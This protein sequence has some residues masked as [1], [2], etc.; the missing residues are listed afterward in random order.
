M[1][2]LLAVAGVG[3]FRGGKLIFEPSEFPRE[4]STC[5]PIGR[6]SGPPSDLRY[7]RTLVGD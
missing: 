7:A 6:E 4:K 2:P 5:A 3:G 1:R